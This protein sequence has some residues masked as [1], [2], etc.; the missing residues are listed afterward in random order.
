MSQSTGFKLIILD[1]ADAMTQPAQAALRRGTIPAFYR[2]HL[3]TL[4]HNSTTSHGKVHQER[5]ILY[6]LQLREQDYPRTAVSLHSLPL[7]PLGARS[8]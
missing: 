5:A 6:H 7:C 2:L 1:E 8:D 3:I 4:L